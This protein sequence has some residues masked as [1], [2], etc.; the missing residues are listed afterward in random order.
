[1]MKKHQDDYIYYDKTESEKLQDE[2]EP[3]PSKYPDDYEYYDQEVDG[4]I[5]RWPEGAEL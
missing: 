2:L 5:T 1:M 3:M 4:E